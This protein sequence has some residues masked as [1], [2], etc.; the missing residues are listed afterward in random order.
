MMLFE[1]NEEQYVNLPFM[2]NYFYYNIML[3]LLTE[4]YHTLSAE[5]ASALM[6]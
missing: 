3:T 2:N 1:K 5:F 4:F 6:S